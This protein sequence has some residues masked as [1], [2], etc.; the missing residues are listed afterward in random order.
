VMDSGLKKVI[1]VNAKGQV[2][3]QAILKSGTDGMV[4]TTKSGLESIKRSWNDMK[5][6]V[7]ASANATKTQV[8]SHISTLGGNI[9]R[10]YRLVQ[11]PGGAG[12]PAGPGPTGAGFMRGLRVSVPCSTCSAPPLPLT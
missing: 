2:K 9:K 5:G 8:T 7:E 10:F 4:K 12:G 3:N 6:K 11:N 1:E